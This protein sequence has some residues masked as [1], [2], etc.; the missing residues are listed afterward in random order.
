M[1]GDERKGFAKGMAFAVALKRFGQPEEIASVALFFATRASSF[2]TG[3]EL[4]VDGGL[5]GV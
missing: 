4:P 1:E 2:V 5:G 3:A